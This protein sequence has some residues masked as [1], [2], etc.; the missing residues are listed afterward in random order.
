MATKVGDVGGAGNI[1][2]EI[3][4]GNL[5]ETVASAMLRA[6]SSRDEFRKIS[7]SPDGAV[8]VRPWITAGGWIL[9]VKNGKIFGEQ[10]GKEIG[11][12]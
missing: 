10:F 11:N 2:A 7:D 5:A 9:I 8:I 3:G 4:I 1:G 6:A 12:G